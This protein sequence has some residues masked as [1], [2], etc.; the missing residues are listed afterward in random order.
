MTEEWGN[1]KRYFKNLEVIA[2]VDLSP[3]AMKRQ[4]EAG[5]F[6]QPEVTSLRENQDK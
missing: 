3:L 2:A 4:R 1:H 5:I 6:S